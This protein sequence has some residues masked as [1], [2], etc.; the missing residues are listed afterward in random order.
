MMGVINNKEIRVFGL[1]RSGNHAIINWLF[2]QIPGVAIFLNNCYPAG[3]KLNLYQGKGQIVGKGI[4]YWDFK[5]KIFFEK[6]PFANQTTV[7]YSKEDRRL[8]HKKLRELPKNALI[9][10]FENRN[11]NQISALLDKKHNELVGN[12]N[13]VFSVIILRDPFN[14]FASVY[15]KW[16]EKSLIQSADLWKEYAQAFMEYESKKSRYFLGINYNNWVTQLSY[17]QSIVEKIQI[18]FDDSAKNVVAN[19]AGGSSFDE[20]SYESDA[21]QMSVFNRWQVFEH[22]EKFRRLFEPEI[23]ELTE[24][25]FGR[26]PGTES[27]F[28]SKGF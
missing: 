2:Y 13:E 1:K 10:S 7:S 21:H 9:I 6:N 26:I 23:I 4:N 22:D 12:S 19:F 8:N 5:R 28:P 11:I 15:K 17:R 18:P 25:I 20:M 3:Q 24:Q 14:L 16:G 27:F